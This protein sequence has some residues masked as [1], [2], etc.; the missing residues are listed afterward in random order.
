MGAI[1]TGNLSQ[2]LWPGL[3]ELFGGSYDNLPKQY[4]QLFSLLKSD[5][6]FERDVN[7]NFFGL[8][9]VKDEGSALAFDVAGQGP[10]K[11][12]QHITYALGYILTME[13]IHYNQYMKLATSYTPRLANSMLQ[14]KETVHFN[15]LNRGFNSSYTG[16]DGV[17]LF[18]SSHLKTGGGTYA[19]MLATPADLS[20][21]SLEQAL[22]DIGG[23]EDDR[24]LKIKANG[25]MLVVPRQLEMEAERILNSSLRPF[26]PNNDIN[27]LKGK[28]SKGI[29]MSHYLS[30]TKA[31]FVKT[32]IDGLKSFQSKELAFDNDTD[33]HTKNMMFSALEM[34]S[35]GWTDPRS[36]YASQGVA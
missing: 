14:T 30:N 26:T 22:I 36:M 3:N 15:T 9:Q 23:F 24:G 31:W 19:N 29:L 1:H 2:L 16:F 7:L 32:N 5:K 20:E 11:D 6:S 8:A 12:Y 21:V 33:F 35:C 27:V 10:Y 4:S 17:E 25:E 18:S 28:L 34:Y 13:A